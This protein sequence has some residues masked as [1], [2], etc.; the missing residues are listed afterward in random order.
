MPQ[1][2][3]DWSR[4]C[5]ALAGRLGIWHPASAESIR[6]WQAPRRP[7]RAM[8]ASGL[9]IEGVKKAL[10]SGFE[11]LLGVATASLFYTD[12]CYKMPQVMPKKIGHKAQVAPKKI[13]PRC[14]V[15]KAKAPGAQLRLQD[16]VNW[17]RRPTNTS[18]MPRQLEHIAQLSSSQ[19]IRSWCP[20]ISIM[21]PSGTLDS[22]P[23]PSTFSHFQARC[24]V[25]GCCLILGDHG[26]MTLHHDG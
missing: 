23:H 21:V 24:Q 7:Q 20:A 6:T 13:G 1:R 16:L 8:S 5:T 4:T 10:W 3:D 12:M 26:H 15:G 19:K 11:G 25:L 9:H 2:H 14:P 17:Q 18:T 22:R